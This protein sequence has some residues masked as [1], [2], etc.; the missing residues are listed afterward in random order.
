[1]VE[2]LV[3]ISVIA[4]LMALLLPAFS[5]VKRQA[6]TVLC[7]SKLRQWNMVL[8]EYAADSRGRFP[9]EVSGWGVPWLP[10]MTPYLDG[11]GENQSDLLLCPVAAEPV[12]WD[13][14]GRVG[15]TFRA[16]MDRPSPDEP[17]RFVCSYGLA[18]GVQRWMVWDAW[19]QRDRLIRVASPAKTPVLVDCINSDVCAGPYDP[20]PPYEGCFKPPSTGPIS[21]C[22]INRHDGGINGLFLDG[23]FR[24]VGLKELWTLEWMPRFNTRGPWTKAGGARPEDWPQWMRAFKDY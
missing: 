1:L 18:T 20:P 16:W 7:Q 14:P 3:V 12:T 4:V 13:A 21:W 22:C 10:V 17:P 2:L 8:R 19:R 11:S 5:R 9:A 23:S 24:K 15:D 6:T